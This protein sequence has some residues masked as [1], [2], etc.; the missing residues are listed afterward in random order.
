MEKIVAEF[1]NSKVFFNEDMKLGK[2]VWNGT[3]DK[4]EYRNPFKALIKY[5][6][7]H[8][9]EVFLSDIT[10]QGLISIENRQWFERQLL[11]EAKALGLKKAAIVTN[12]NTFRL[13]YISLIINITNRFKIPVKLFSSQERAEKWLLADSLAEVY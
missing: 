9:V 5:A 3:P 7:T 12:D 8:K 11:P 10:H 13:N 4:V 6:E 2:I 1:L